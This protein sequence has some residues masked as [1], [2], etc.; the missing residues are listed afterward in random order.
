MTAALSVVIPT[1]DRPQVLQTTL[2]RIDDGGPEDLSLQVVV[3]DDG[4]SVPV[5]EAVGALGPFRYDLVVLRQEPRGPAAARNRG[6][7]AAEAARVLLLGDDTPPVAGG[8]EGHAIDDEVGV[9]GFIDW[10]PELE[11]TPVMRFLA[12]AGPQFYF[13]G[14]AEGGPVPWTGVLGSNLSAPA[15]WFREEPFDERFEDACLEDTELAWR[16][17]R[18]GWR[19]IFRRHAA[20]WH[21]HAYDDLEPFLERQRRAGRWARLALRLHPAMAWRL[22]AAPM[23]FTPIVAVRALVQQRARWDLRCR[24]AFVDG[25]LSGEPHSST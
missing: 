19:V 5:R 18:R 23:A 16:W 24:R 20:C 8:L 12:P 11:R 21:H 3:V 17:Q 6:I 4:S 10:S 22:V 25:L 13:S 14:L 1:R 7:A 15:R 9:Q 2:A